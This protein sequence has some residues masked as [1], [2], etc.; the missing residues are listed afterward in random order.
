MRY[1]FLRLICACAVVTACGQTTTSS[2]TPTDTSAGT[3][4]STTGGDSTD[5]ALNDTGVDPFLGAPPAICRTGTIW[6]NQ[7]A[8]SDVT[9]LAFSVDVTQV[10]GTSISSADINGDFLP[11]LPACF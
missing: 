5:D 1:P 11:D 6:T 3:D 4:G 2:T 10:V 7:H 8:F 9:P